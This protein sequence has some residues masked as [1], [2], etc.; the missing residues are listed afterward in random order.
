M[1]WFGYALLGAG[2]LVMIGVGYVAYELMNRK[3]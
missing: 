2:G 1:P 3:D